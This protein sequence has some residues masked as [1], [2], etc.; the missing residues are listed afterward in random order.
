MDNEK[1]AM[2]Y[3]RKININP[4]MA[5]NK[6]LARITKESEVL[7]FGPASG[8][9]TRVMREDMGCKVSIVELDEEAFNLAM[10]YA[11]DGICTNIES[12]EW[13]DKFEEKKF[14]YIIFVDVLEHL[15]NAEQVLRE[16]KLLLKP[17]GSVLISVPNIAHNS[18]IIQLMNNQFIYQNTG[19]LDYTH[20]H[21]FTFSELERMCIA[22]GLGFVYIDATY[23]SVGKNEFDI[24]YQDV[25]PVIADFLRKRPFGE[26]YQH[27]VELKSTDYIEDKAI[28]I[29]ECLGLEKIFD[30]LKIEQIEVSE[31]QN[32]ST[33]AKIFSLLAS[34]PNLFF[35]N[36]NEIARMR[37][38]INE[39]YEAMPS[40]EDIV[41]LKNRIFNYQE[42]VRQK[43][44]HIKA[45]TE[46]NEGL[47]YV[48]R[49]LESQ[50]T[51][52]LQ[53][54]KNK[55]I[56]IEQLD[57]EEKNNKRKIEE[58]TEA[59][60]EN[61][62][63]IWQLI[64]IE[65]DH[66]QIIQNR[67]QQLIDLEFGYKRQIE[68]S[69]QLEQA[70]KSQIEQLVQS[71]QGNK[72]RIEQLLQSEREYKSQ[73]EQLSQAEQEYKQ[74]IELLMKAE[75]DFK[76]VIQ[77]EEKQVEKL[78]NAE[79]EYK[80]RIDQLTKI[81]QEYRERIERLE[82][83][84]GDYKQTILNKEGHI[85]QL[86]EVEREYE[87]E[88]HSR[89]YRLALKF[90]KISLALFPVNS[91]R[92][93]FA[94]MLKKG[95]CHPRLML[96]MINL[97][98]IKNFFVI[99]KTE[100]MESVLHHY[101]LVEEV[102]TSRL[103]PFDSNKF[104][105]NKIETGEQS[106]KSISDYDVITFEETDSPL[107]SIVIPVYNQFEYTYNCL[108]SIKEQS[109]EVSY[110]ILIADDC[111]TD[112]TQNIKKLVKG[113]KVIR[114]KE[115][116]R[117]LRNC[118][119]AAQK[120]K[121]KYILFLNN[122]TQ[123]QKDWLQ[124]LIDLM[125][126]P[127]VGMV[128]SKL[129]YADGWLQ[130]AGGIVWDDASAWNFG[131]RKNPD[132]PEYNYVK[133]VDYISGAA[134]MIRASLWKE[135]GGFDDNFAPAYY[136]DTDLA[137]EVRKNGYKVMYQPLSVVVHFEG[138]SNGTDV[139][140]GQKA[141]QVENQKKFYQK[142]KDVLA[143]ENFPNGENVFIAKDRSRFKKQML[144]VDHY[145]PHYDQDA[146]GKC[147][148]MYLKLMVKMG[149]KVTFIG[150]NFY[151]HEP[152]TTDLNQNGIEVLYG[153]FYYNNWQ[154]WLKEN[155]HYFDY[156]YLQRPHISVKYIDIVKQNCNAKVFYFAHDLHHVREMREYE[157]TKNEET[158][159]SAEHWKQI[160]YDLFEKADVGH[161]VGS[162]EQAIMQKAFPNKPI[163]NI[164][165]YIY[166]DVP[167]GISKDFANRNDL[168]YVGGFGHPPNIDA[169]LWFAE[170]VFPSILK[171]LPDI[172]WHVVGGKV[173]DK[174]KEL[175]NEHIIIEGFLSDE[176]LHELYRNCRM[177]VV[178]LR[179]GAGVK[180]KV[181]ESA[182]FQI[183]LV[184][185]SIGA[186]GIDATI[187]NMIV[188]D[189]A[190]QMAKII[191]ETYVDPEK[192][193]RMSDAGKT[194]IQ[195]YYTL[196][197]AERVLLQDL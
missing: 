39:I 80:D 175:A 3:V 30:T 153:N 103:N 130:E 62:Q 90:R 125:N 142:W 4:E 155:L 131:N 70:Y 112:L 116:L 69:A 61:K 124:P 188:T 184:T 171:M 92:R 47:K 174:I 14:D 177:A 135:I 48:N 178:P 11:V 139:T 63:K 182:Y 150:D 79:Q 15:H 118:N 128:G 147:T 88:K 66:V 166:D 35:E 12:F 161:V 106:K 36:N 189:D 114:N 93:F 82:R 64:E 45:V 74:H 25:D 126:D 68:Q 119:H 111:S 23:I 29:E 136:E 55:E 31:I 152:Y 96:H 165:L 6:I 197:E 157:I 137:F 32:N 73:I 86:L 75:K 78:T 58:L 41:G 149:F 16:A 67:D 87:R 104:K 154:E 40:L 140:S 113:I 185:T 83:T 21:H 195:K 143:T 186:E 60:H 133:E 57:K 37:L 134:I 115:N 34:N 108:A 101:K 129:V 132:D 187:G 99:S 5:H 33:N 170:S 121:G 156:V 27:I 148:Y 76:Q 54:V 42:E 193:R 117:F 17:G 94:S 84:E 110:E 109:G 13:I 191:C 146:G 44:K 162:Y 85:E 138:I 49:E 183:P 89:T 127:K 190:D 53:E 98:R 172:R 19:L 194:L 168:L 120:A 22:V 1:S 163:R 81:E 26:V 46:E 2:R 28:Q 50:N 43:N 122:D 59:E 158:F 173:P 145:V 20:V 151:K 192:L 71:E 176:E 7:E 10:Q 102:E 18:I 52:L 77:D 72:S 38:Q 56:Y 9:M 123:V 100:G 24:S 95:I 159:K 167:E 164:P 8:V 107:V 97:R 65:K 91:K 144:V 181:V 196:Q 141:Y 169:V 51:Y 180:G 179:Y 160:E 105:I